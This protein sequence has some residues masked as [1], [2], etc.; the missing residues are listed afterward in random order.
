MEIR[1]LE[2]AE[3]GKTRF[4]WEKIFK[5]DSQT[6]V[7]YYYFIRTKENVIYVVEE[8]GAIRS[9][10][11][12][13]PYW[14]KLEDSVFDSEYIVGVATEKEYRSRGY[15]RQLLIAALEEE[16]KKKHPFTFL[17]PAAEAIYSPYD[18][19]YIYHQKQME[20]DSDV[21]FALKRDKKT[22]EKE[23]RDRGRQERVTRDAEL[24]D[25]ER[26]AAF[27]EK[28]ESPK[29][30]VCTVRDSVY[31]QTKILEQQ[32]ESGG[33]RL[34]FE[35]KD[36]VG[37]FFY[38]REDILEILEPVILQEK[39]N[40]FLE[41]VEELRRE[42]ELVKI[43]GC[44]EKMRECDIDGWRLDVGDEISHFFWKN[45]RKA[46]KAVKKDM[47][48]IGEIWHYAGDFLEG[49]EWDTVMNYPFYLN[50][51]D[52]LADE[53]ITVS[54]FVQNLGYLKGRLNKNC[55]P[56]MWNLIDSHD[57]ARF[58]H[59]C[60]DNK[61]K[62]HLA[63]AFQ[64]LL[65]GMPM[66]YYGD[67]YAMPGANDPDCRRGMY[68]DEEYQDKEMYEW[69]KRL[70]QVRKSHACIVEGELAGSVTEDEEGT[71]VLIR[72][73][74]EETIAMI[75]NCSSSAKKFNE[76]TQK[77]NLL[78]ENTFD[79]NVEGFDAAVIVL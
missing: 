41:A 9:M 36:L 47:L 43:L 4:L 60:N 18:F 35:E 32:S 31:Y 61:K 77:Y 62:Q 26:I 50:L 3:H 66:I 40:A 48:I 75:F 33:V 37:V 57:T 11:Q 52:L 12:K 23:S 24:G 59:L 29:W 76:Y 28:N 73:N 39:E 16:N 19:R 22:G 70:I 67:E 56:L 38:A 2:S 79:G 65:P 46:V 15:M 42:K 51:I 13:N 44:T 55:Y 25:A 14:M 30:A 54:Q 58:L 68:W 53:K 45:F 63:A 20:L 6:F 72:K 78:T 7:D 74:G 49:D 17:M 27:F 64:L 34:I 71:V 10:L 8:D 69:Y 21:F 1:K 5:E